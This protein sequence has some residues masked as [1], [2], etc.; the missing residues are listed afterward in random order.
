MITGTIWALQVFDLDVVM[1]GWNPQRFN[2]LLNTHIFREFKN[3]RLGY[4]ATVGVVLLSMIAAIT[5]AQ[6]RWL[7]AGSGGRA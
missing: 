7:R 1:N 6:F 2:D 3:G 5:Y 4:S